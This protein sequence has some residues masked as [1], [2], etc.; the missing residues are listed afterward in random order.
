[1]IVG[2]HK[3]VGI[4]YRGSRAEKEAPLGNGGRGAYLDPRAVFVG[5]RL[6]RATA[7]AAFFESLRGTPRTVFPDVRGGSGAA[8][9]HTDAYGQNRLGR[10]VGL[11][12]EHCQLQT[13]V[14][15]TVVSVI[16]VLQMYFRAGG[17]ADDDD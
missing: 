3:S 9:N 10:S 1:L 17:I 13:A 6:W 4:V 7:P 11:Q 5:T 15:A 12:R 8:S 16:N 14:S 2:A